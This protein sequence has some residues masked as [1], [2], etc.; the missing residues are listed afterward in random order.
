M[1]VHEITI[2]AHQIRLIVCES[3]IFHHFNTDFKTR[4]D[5]GM[6]LHLEKGGDKNHC[7]D[8]QDNPFCC[9]FWQLLSNMA[10]FRYFISIDFDFII[11]DIRLRFVNIGVGIWNETANGK[12]WCSTVGG[13]S[14]M[15][16]TFGGIVRYHPV[17][18][19]FFFRG[20]RS[21]LNDIRELIIWSGCFLR[22]IFFMLGSFVCVS[23]LV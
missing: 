2:R 3:I 19:N 18:Y 20:L 13:C 14:I 22:L 1:S 4:R 23:M 17:W 9:H 8:N 11:I 6:G 10:F 5:I 12:H 21:W 15:L 16:K 7:Q